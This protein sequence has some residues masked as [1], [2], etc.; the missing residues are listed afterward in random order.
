MSNSGEVTRI[1]ERITGGENQAFDELLPLVYEQLRT[2]AQRQMRGMKPGHTLQPT[3]LVNE[4][5]LK[6][7]GP[8][9]HGWE[10]RAHFLNAAAKAMRHVLVD[11]ARKRLSGKRGGDRTREPQQVM[12]SAVKPFTLAISLRMVSS[13]P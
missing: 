11:Y 3:A 4:A 5:C 8:G 1:L 2:I 10:S 13:G 6:M 12:E 9:P 7:L